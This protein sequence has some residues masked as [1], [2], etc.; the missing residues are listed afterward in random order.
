MQQA[1]LNSGSGA[2]EFGYK[3]DLQCIIG[4]WLQVAQV[5]EAYSPYLEGMAVSYDNGWA[6]VSGR[7]KM[8]I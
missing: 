5:K 1:W 3:M 2:V 8:V 6:C 7:K 4:L